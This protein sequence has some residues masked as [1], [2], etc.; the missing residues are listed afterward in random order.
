[1]DDGRRN[2]DTST[3]DTATTGTPQQNKTMKLRRSKK[4]DDGELALPGRAGVVTLVRPSG[5]RVQA[6]VAESGPDSLLV[7]LMFVTEVPLR[8]AELDRLVLEFTTRRGRARLQG[9]VVQEERDLLRFR[10]LRSLAV[11][12]ERE[13]VRVPTARPVTVAVGSSRNSVNT[14]SV[15]V[16]GGGMLLAG[17]ATLKVGERV[18]FRIATAKGGTP[19]T[20]S[21]TVVRID[22]QGRRAICFD[23]ISEGDHRRLVK[24]VFE[25]QRV[26]R[27]RGLERGGRN[28]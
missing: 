26:E 1:M 12:Q 9:Q 22:N 19:I 5:E 8:T 11:V 27:R 20:G 21:A 6:R 14:Y 15:D 2:H 13:Y 28:G 4:D 3:T 23:E 18:D 10:A 25:C 24:F 16:S 17:P 7:A